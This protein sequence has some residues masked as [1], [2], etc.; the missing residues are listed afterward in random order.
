MQRSIQRMARVLFNTEAMCAL[1]C[2]LQTKSYFQDS[3][4]HLQVLERCMQ[5]EKTVSSIRKFFV[6]PIDCQETV[7]NNREMA[8]NACNSV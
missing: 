8:R 6:V 3:V 7:K 1:S 2:G 5:H 4:F